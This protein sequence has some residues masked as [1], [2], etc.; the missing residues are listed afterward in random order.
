[1]RLDTTVAS[2][3]AAFFKKEAIL[4]ATHGQKALH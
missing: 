2:V 4:I 1:M 3:A